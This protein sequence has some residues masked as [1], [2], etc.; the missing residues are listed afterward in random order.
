MGLMIS[1]NG[2]YW[3]SI[4][5]IAHHFAHQAHIV[6]CLAFAYIPNVVRRY[7]AGPN[8]VLSLVIVDSIKM[9]IEFISYYQL[10]AIKKSNYLYRV[11]K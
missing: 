10:Y 2:K 6:S 8:P 4:R 9:I 11:D 1:N 7:V 5:I 3:H